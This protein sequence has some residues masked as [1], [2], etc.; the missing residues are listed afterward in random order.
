[1]YVYV[2]TGYGKSDKAKWQDVEKSSELGYGGFKVCSQ[3]ILQKW[4]SLIPFL[5]GLDSVIIF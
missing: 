2:R 3:I 4:W 1:M 5:C